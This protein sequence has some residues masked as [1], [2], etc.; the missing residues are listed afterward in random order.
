MSLPVLL[1]IIGSTRPGRI[2]PAFADWFA[3]LA[4]EHGG[5]EVEVADLA[6]IDLP[7]FNEP[8]HPRFGDY[9]HDHTKAW[10]ATVARAD[11]VVFVVPE[12]NYGYNAATK[13]AIDYLGREWADKA[14]S[15]VSYGGIAGG[16]RAVQQLKQVLTTLRMLPVFESIN[17]PFAAQQLDEQGRVKPDPARDAAGQV[18]LDE[19]LRV[20]RLLRPATVTA[21][22]AVASA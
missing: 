5:F 3:D 13:N 20:T 16:T 12:Y 6:E 2:G 8:K 1:V 19:L 18:M 22:G 11:A 14:V 9:L 7:L 4:R 17:V 21:T 15:F 10:S